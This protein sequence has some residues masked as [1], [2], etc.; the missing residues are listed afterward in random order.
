MNC[1]LGEYVGS[2]EARSGP[3]LGFTRPTRRLSQALCS[4]SD[5]RD[6]ASQ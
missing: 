1:M 6:A 5:A 2:S 4:H 3:V